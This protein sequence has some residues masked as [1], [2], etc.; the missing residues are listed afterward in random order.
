MMRDGWFVLL[1]CND[2]TIL[3]FFLSFYLPFFS[4][5]LGSCLLD[6]D[7]HGGTFDKSVDARLTAIKRSSRR[8]KRISRSRQIFKPHRESETSQTGGV[9]SFLNLRS[10]ADLILLMHEQPHKSATQAMA[11]KYV[12]MMMTMMII[13]IPSPT[14]V[15]AYRTS[16]TYFCF[17]SPIHLSTNFQ[18]K[19]YISLHYTTCSPT[20][21]ITTGTQSRLYHCSPRI[22]ACG[23]IYMPFSFPQ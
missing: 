7:T 2:T 14:L 19:N 8:Y 1:Y 12:M 17:R 23:E 10:L 15:L 13:I 21:L 20:A 6:R 5:S 9:V 4:S 22:I 16:I 11:D 3:S 18:Y